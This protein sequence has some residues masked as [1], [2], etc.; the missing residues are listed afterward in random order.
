VVHDET[1]APQHHEKTPVAEPA[2]L[3][4]DRLY[5]LANLVVVGTAG[6]VANRHAAAADG[7]IRPPFAHPEGILQAGDSF[8]LSRGRHHFFPTRSFRAALSSMASASR[9]FSRAFSVLQRLQAARLGDVHAAEAG[10]PVVDRGVA[11]PVLAAQIGD[12]YPSLVFLQNF[13]DLLF[14]EAAALHVLVLSMGQN[15]LQSGLD[16]RGQRQGN[17]RCCRAGSCRRSAPR[18]A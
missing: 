14:R 7:F 17:R 12:R 3:L 4:R 11:D 10:L 18:R 6:L 9:R 5:P 15:E 8:P 2:S 1:L 13:D 16:R